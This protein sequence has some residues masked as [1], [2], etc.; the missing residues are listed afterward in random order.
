MKIPIRIIIEKVN[1]KETKFSFWKG[2]KNF[3]N[4]I[5]ILF[6]QGILTSGSAF[7]RTTKNAEILEDYSL[8]KS[9]N[10]EVFEFMKTLPNSPNGILEITYESDTN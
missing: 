7:Y 9:P 1:S 5:K 10:R 4:N 8:F 2:V 3:L 6:T